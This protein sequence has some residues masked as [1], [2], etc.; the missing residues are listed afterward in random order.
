MQEGPES[1]QQKDNVLYPILRE[2]SKDKD[3]RW[4]T[5]LLVMFWP[6]LEMLY[7]QKV[8]LDKDIEERWSNLV[9][10]FL[11]TIHRFNLK[12]RSSRLA[13]KIINLTAHRLHD[14]YRRLSRQPEFDFIGAHEEFDDLTDGVE[15]KGFEAVELS[16]FQEAEFKRLCA[17]LEAGTIKK[18]DFILLVSTRIYEETVAEYARKTG[19]SYECAKRRRS[20]AEARIARKEKGKEKK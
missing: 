1:D 20:R 14:E 19:L 6:A 10:A 17:H 18:R 8:K 16:D 12:N 11:V 7:F 2:H 9:Y 13:Q 3:P 15:E 4:R 5:I